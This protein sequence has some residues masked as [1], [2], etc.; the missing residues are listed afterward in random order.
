MLEFDPKQK[1][2]KPFF[3]A[4]EKRFAKKCL[5]FG[6]VVVAVFFC[7]C[8]IDFVFDAMRYDMAIGFLN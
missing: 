8:A 5:I 7:C 6:V 3:S 1:Q 2:E 4:P